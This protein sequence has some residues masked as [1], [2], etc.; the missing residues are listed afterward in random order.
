MEGLPAWSGSLAG[1]WTGAKCTGACFLGFGCL[2]FFFYYLFFIAPF[3]CT[4]HLAVSACLKCLLG[5]VAQHLLSSPLCAWV[6]GRA[7]HPAGRVPAPLLLPPRGQAPVTR[8]WAC[9]GCCSGPTLTRSHCHPRHQPCSAASPQLNSAH[10]PALRYAF[11]F[12]REAWTECFSNAKI[13]S[14]RLTS[15]YEWALL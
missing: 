13:M 11:L 8:C 2:C 14:L 15:D 10:F 3:K 7:Q 9:A 6:R 1:Q 12:T 5:G 4:L